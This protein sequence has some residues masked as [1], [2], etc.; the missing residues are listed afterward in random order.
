MKTEII[1]EATG[2]RLPLSPLLA[3][4]LAGF[5]TILTEAIPAGML[6]QI[7]VSLGVS[8][9]FAGQLVTLYALGSLLAAIPLTIAT[10]T[11]RRRPLLLCAIAGFAVANTITSFSGS[12]G[13]TLVARFIAGVSAGLLW[14]LI[15]GYAARMVKDELKGRAIAL[16]MTGTPL[17]LSIGIPVGTWLS[18]LI[19]WRSCF[20]IISAIT[21]V[22]IGWVMF[23]VPDYPGQFAAKRLSLRQVLRMSGIRSVLAATLLFVLAHNIIYTYIAPFLQA[24]SMGNRISMVL[25]V[26]GIASLFGIWGVGVLVD[27]WLRELTLLAIVL[28]AFS[29]LLLAARTP[30]IIYLASAIWGLAFG[31]SATLFQTALAKTAKDAADVAQSMLVTAWNLAIA[32]GGLAGAALL[33]EEGAQLFSPVL[34]LLLLLALLT[35]WTARRH[36]FPS[37]CSG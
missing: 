26:F 19:G 34:M 10:Q 3:L 22:L 11:L 35:V 18:D 6:P 36:G 15:A 14:A 25:L 27:K 7:G 31:G 5:I 4:A 16:A 23:S 2:D 20:Y 30:V 1:T 17:A 37:T 24:A 28:F 33:N 32:G 12:Y 13:L 29:I 8:D 9:A 21:L